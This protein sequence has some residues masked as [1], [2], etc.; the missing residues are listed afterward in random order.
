MRIDD[1]A[2]GQTNRGEFNVH[3]HPL[4]DGRIAIG[5]FTIQRSSPAGRQRDGDH[6]EPHVRIQP[7]LTMM[8]MNVR[9]FSS[10]LDILGPPTA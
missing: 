2:S 10:A 8:C 3:R 6:P 1:D 7:G 4:R 9:C 5:A